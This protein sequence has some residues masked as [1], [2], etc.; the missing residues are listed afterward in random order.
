MSGKC[1]GGVPQLC[2]RAKRWSATGLGVGRT[3][4]VP[5]TMRSTPSGRYSRCFALGPNAGWTCEDYQAALTRSGTLHRDRLT[6]LGAI[7][8][9]SNVRDSILPRTREIHL[10]EV[11][12]SGPKSLPELPVTLDIR[13]GVPRSARSLWL[14]QDD[15]S[16]HHCGLEFPDCGDCAASVSMTAICSCCKAAWNAS[17]TSWPPSAGCLSPSATSPWGARAT[18]TC[19]PWFVTNQR[20]R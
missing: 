18:C 7:A 9:L 8:T 4:P 10:V 19:L 17:T 1:R 13:E 5:L 20:Y 3:L 11:A 12:T 2:D 16:A 15:P 14:G 6:G